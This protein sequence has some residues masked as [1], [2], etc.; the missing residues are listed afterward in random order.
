MLL[1]TSDL[2]FKN[3]DKMKW[4]SLMLFLLIGFVT[5]IQC[6]SLAKIKDEG[7]SQFNEKK[8][9]AA[10]TNLKQ[11]YDTKQDNIEVNTALG[12][13]AYETNKLGESVVLLQKGE[14]KGDP[15]V[16]YYLARAMHQSEKF[17]E[18]IK[19]YKMYLKVAK[20]NDVMRPFVIEEI[21]RA[22]SG[23]RAVNDSENVIVENFGETVNTIYD[24]FAPLPSPNVESKIYFSATNSSSIGGMRNDNGESSAKGHYCA[25]MYSTLNQNGNWDVPTPLNEM[26][27]GVKNEIAVDFDEKGKKLYFFKGFSTFSGELLVNEFDLQDINGNVFPKL[28][29][30]FKPEQ[31]DIT[32]HFFRDS[33]VLFSSRSITGYGGSDIYYAILNKDNI[34]GDP[35][36]LGSAVNT[37]FDEI[38]PFLSV[39][40]RTLYFSSN[41]Y[42]SIGGYDIFRTTYND[43]K[44]IWNSAINVGMPIN[45]PGDDTH[46][47][48]L[49]DAFKGIFCS[50]RKSGF[51]QRDLYSVLFKS[52]RKEQT[53]PSNPL[54]FHMAKGAILAQNENKKKEIIKYEISPVYY[55][56]DNDL[57]SNNNLL[58]ISKVAEIMKTYENVK[59]II[60]ANSDNTTSPVNVDIYF[61]MKKGE[62]IMNKLIE[63]GVPKSRIIL[64]S[65]GGYYPVARNELNGT[66]FVAGQKLNRRIEFEFLDVAEY[67]IAID[68]GNLNLPEHIIDRRSNTFK[69]NQ[70]GIHYRFQIG[71]SK[72]LL[73]SNILETVSDPCL[74]YDNEEQTYRYMTGWFT[75]FAKAEQSRIAYS[76]S[77]NIEMQVIPYINGQR[78]TLEEVKNLS[79][80]YPDLLNYITK[81]K[82]PQTPK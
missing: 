44:M 79:A 52:Y 17:K 3:V 54:S 55:T 50:D 57:L 47:R 60:S 74:E 1:N 22:A 31:G 69:N 9:L 30:P 28:I 12:I 78:Q 73:E 81:N 25:D 65:F 53:E 43:E 41:N 68:Y 18:A 48:L 35:I 77:E 34:W 72:S 21:K 46:F 10:Y 23:V 5:T 4:R 32:M 19:Y 80:G 51:G 11:Y 6:Q 61:T 49:N 8:Y 71:N 45:S 66:K 29:V 63:L 27:N 24:E 59:L 7:I 64:K 76:K 58:S 40:G 75:E 62:K 15:I 67:P 13:C 20:S 36:N 2:N 70:K 33:I 42:N 82:K 16:L 56:T 14:E 26:L 37:P 38:C 39:D